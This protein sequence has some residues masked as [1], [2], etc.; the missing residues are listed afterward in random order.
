MTTEKPS[1]E[2]VLPELTT[3]QLDD[4]M[5]DQLVTDLENA[6]TVLDV[7]FKGHATQRTD[8]KPVPIRQAV[9]LLRAGESFGVQIRYIFEETEWR[10]TLSRAS[11][12]YRLV[13]MAIPDLG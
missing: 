12:G 6:A 13:R 11:T 5:L 3:A 9:S 8:G 10:D 4:T 2:L 7:L 1:D